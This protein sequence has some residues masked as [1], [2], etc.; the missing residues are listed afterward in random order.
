M[1]KNDFKLQI[2]ISAKYFQNAATF[3]SL[4]RL[5]YIPPFRGDKFA[6]AVSAILQDTVLQKDEAEVPEGKKTIN[7]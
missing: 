6:Q 7:Q 3:T 5:I 2:Q 4:L 1:Q